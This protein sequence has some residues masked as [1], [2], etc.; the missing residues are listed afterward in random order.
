MIREE[1]IG[2][3]SIL[4]L[5]VLAFY[6][7]PTYERMVSSNK[8]DQSSP[9]PVVQQTLP[10]PSTTQQP[11]ANDP[12]DPMNDYVLKSSLVPCS[13]PDYS[14]SCPTH[15]GSAPSSRYPGDK[16]SDITDMKPDQS[17]MR[18]SFPN[19]SGDPQPFLTG[20]GAFNR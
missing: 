12:N 8:G 16:D 11:S 19:Q 13:C 2:Y 1:V 3:A 20:F 5:V 4:L 7:M 10:P 15:A 17:G 9:T 18:K 14:G 6:L